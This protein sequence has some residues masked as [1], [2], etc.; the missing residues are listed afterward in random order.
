MTTSSTLALYADVIEKREYR[1]PPCPTRDGTD[2]R[3]G[4]GQSRARAIHCGCR[5]AGTRPGKPGPAANP[6]PIRK[7]A[8]G[9]MAVD[10]AAGRSGD[11]VGVRHAARNRVGR[12]ATLATL[13]CFSVWW[14]SARRW[15]V[16]CELS[17]RRE[18][19][20][21]CLL[22]FL[23]AATLVRPYFVNISTPISGRPSRAISSRRALSHGAL[24]ASPVA[25]PVYTGTRFDYI[26]PPALRYRHRYRLH[27][28]GFWPVK[29][30]HFYTTF[31]YS[32]ALSAS[33]S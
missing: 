7:D 22:L 20:L 30:Y 23:C 6:L 1:L 33:I 32:W 14:Y 27:G 3:C 8:M 12:V 16:S 17:R 18:I 28:H 5:K 10:A 24:A 13:V 26:Y 29:A 25:A 2:R 9:F 15:R 11:P 21:D 4:A 19:L 31:F